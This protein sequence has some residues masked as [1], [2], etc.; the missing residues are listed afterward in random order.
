MIVGTTQTG[1]SSD[2]LFSNRSASRAPSPCAPSQKA[3]RSQVQTGKQCLPLTQDNS[4]AQ[5]AGSLSVLLVDTAV[6]WKHASDFDILIARCLFREPQRIFD[7]GDKVEGCPPPLLAAPVRGSSERTWRVVGRVIAP[8]SLPGVVGPRPAHRTDMLRP[9]INAPKVLH[10]PPCEFVVH[11]NRSTFLPCIAQNVLVWRTTEKS[12]DRVCPADRS[13]SVRSRAEP[14]N[15]T[16]NPHSNL[17]H[18]FMLPASKI[19]AV[20]D[21]RRA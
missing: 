3:Q 2:Y 12:R 20:G 19:H 21:S 13:G 5:S 8:P 9:M 11:I 15:E 10:R 7:S 18:I 16:A 6:P 14:V 4:Q 1:S 17:R